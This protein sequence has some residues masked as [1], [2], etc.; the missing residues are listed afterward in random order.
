MFDKEINLWGSSVGPGENNV[1][2]DGL[3]TSTATIFTVDNSDGFGALCENKGHPRDR[4][5]R[6]VLF[7]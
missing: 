6:F 2:W 7:K 3:H 4:G 5:P 1:V